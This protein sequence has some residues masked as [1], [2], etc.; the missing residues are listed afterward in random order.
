MLGKL[1]LSMEVFFPAGGGINTAH[2]KCYAVPLLRNA[3]SLHP[4]LL[5]VNR[6]AI[7]YTASKHRIALDVV[8]H[9]NTRK[10]FH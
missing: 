2:N 8:R 5:A 10:H 6:Y 9:I 3:E 1:Y 7:Y 4:Y